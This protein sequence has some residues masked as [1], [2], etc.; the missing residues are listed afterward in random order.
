MKSALVL[1]AAL[2]MA[3]P[4]LSVPTVADAQVLTGRG[5]A[6]PAR[7]PRPAPPRL[8]DAEQD[9]LWDA[10]SEIG[11]LDEQIAEI[12]AAGQTQGGLTPEQQAQINAHAARRTELQANVTRL[13]AKLDR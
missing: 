4:A 3:M 12:Q 11:T 2:V 8:T 5:R 6:T 1:A 10:K 13:E 9:Q 7:R